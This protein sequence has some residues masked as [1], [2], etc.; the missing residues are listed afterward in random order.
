MRHNRLRAFD[1]GLILLGQATLFAART[2]IWAALPE[3]GLDTLLE[4]PGLAHPP[5]ESRGPMGGPRPS[6]RTPV[7]SA[8]M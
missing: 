3:A 4:G 5:A 1:D 7:E 6:M 8:R 2:T